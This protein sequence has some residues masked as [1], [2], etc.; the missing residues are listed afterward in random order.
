M[1]C[2]LCGEEPPNGYLMIGV[3]GYCHTPGE[4]RSCYTSTRDFGDWM[5]A[6]QR[7][8]ARGTPRPR[9]Y[10]AT[11]TREGAKWLGD[12]PAVPG[13]HTQADSITGLE[14]SLREVIVLMTDRPDGDVDDVDAFR[15]ALQAPR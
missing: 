5:R 6:A 14:R 15:V 4:P 12:V 9:V 10:Q 13:A 7:A 2:A 11:V 1:L 3:R 8:A